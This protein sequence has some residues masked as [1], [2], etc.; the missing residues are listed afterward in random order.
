MA[1]GREAPP[2]RAERA[3]EEVVEVEVEVEEEVEVEVEV[4]VGEEAE[5]ELPPHSPYPGAAERSPGER[6]QGEDRPG[7]S[8][9]PQ[10]PRAGL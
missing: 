3:D 6:A 8:E 2:Q 1:R 10:A 9:V 4:E 7:D 5:V